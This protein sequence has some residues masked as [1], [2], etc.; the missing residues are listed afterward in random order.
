MQNSFQSHDIN[1]YFQYY[2][3]FPVVLFLQV[4]NNI[5]IYLIILALLV[6]CQFSS[7][8]QSCPTVCD[9]INHSTPGLPV[10]HQ[11][12]EFTQSHVH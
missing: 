11:L 3:S 4:F 12:L 5:N 10:H 8:V 7:L 9:P 1:L 2:M 6:A